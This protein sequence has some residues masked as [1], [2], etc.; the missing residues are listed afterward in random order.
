MKDI[1]D[2]LLSAYVDNELSVTEVD[3]FEQKVPPEIL[4]HLVKEKKLEAAIS[5][6]LKEAPA[7]PEKLWADILG[8]IHE[9]P[10][11]KRISF[12]KYY[13]SAALA[14]AATLFIT[15]SGVFKSYPV[16]VPQTVSELAQNSAVK[17]DRQLVNQFISANG[18]QLQLGKLPETHH[19]R[20]LS[21]VGAAL[22]NIAGDEVVAVYFDCCGEL[23]KVYF[24][25]KESRA[26]KF[27]A[28][29]DKKWHSGI[30]ENVE[31]GD[32]SIALVSQ[33]SAGEILDSISDDVG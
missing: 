9:D 27:M 10:A 25:P 8:E 11:V 32:Y 19:G 20:P 14:V 33:H 2:N 3:E 12:Q 6:N 18:V 15:F 17:I 22:E 5:G 28:Q 23:A 29:E 30:V 26:E 31:R 4:S 21:L 24:L 16:W 13:Y 7:C 1:D